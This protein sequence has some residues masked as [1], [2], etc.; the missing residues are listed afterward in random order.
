MRMVYIIEELSDI[1]LDVNPM[2]LGGVDEA[3]IRVAPEYFY[4][5]GS[6]W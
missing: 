2:V 3:L 6:R 4:E 1:C 5:A